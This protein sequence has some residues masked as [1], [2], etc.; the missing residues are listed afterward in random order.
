MMCIGYFY[1]FNFLYHTAEYISNLLTYEIEIICYLLLVFTNKNNLKY[2]ICMH[3]QHTVNGTSKHTYFH[4]YIQ[5]HSLETMHYMYAGWHNFT[6]SHMKTP[7]LLCLLTKL[8]S[9]VIIDKLDITKKNTFLTKFGFFIGQM[10]Q[11][12]T[13]LNL[14]IPGSIVWHT[15]S[16]SLEPFFLRIHFR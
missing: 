10:D 8:T 16:T 7:C 2:N 9:N 11:V 14:I 12:K 5:L 13:W 4:T 3:I 6:H 15:N 1:T